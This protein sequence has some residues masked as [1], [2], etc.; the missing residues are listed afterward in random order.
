MGPEDLDRAVQR[1]PPEV[2]PD[3]L[4]GI[5]TSD[6]AGV[7]R[8]A[9][10]RALV[11]TVDLIT[12]V[13]DDPF[14]FG[15]I[16]AANS[17]SDVYAMGGVPLTAM[18]ILAFPVGD[19]SLEVAEQILLGGLAAVHEAGAVLVGGHSVKDRELKYGLSVTGMVHP[20][21]IWRNRGTL[22]GDVAILTKPLGTGIVATAVKGGLAR[23]GWV[24][25][26]VHQASALNRR[27]AEI[28]GGYPVRACT[29]ITGFG[30]GG[31][32]LEVARASG[33]VLEVETSRLPL[34]PGALES[35]RMGLVPAGGHTNRAHFGAW[36]TVSETVSREMLDIVFD[37]QTS[38]GLAVLVAEEAA[39][40]CL[41]ALS[42]AHLAAARIGRV[43]GPEPCGRLV[44]R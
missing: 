34:L 20:R 13:V 1:L 44:L 38:G 29:D 37:P 3:L 8:I 30:L 35:A 22:P 15:R 6:D 42:G 24:E 33:M 12:P 7:F 39:P 19:L 16:A 27:A 28:L 14:A 9:E 36:T 21:R 23:T 5:E 18:N 10:D 32:L 2:H 31:H 4:V 26:M 41:A 11:Q 40:D 43:V 17:L 25:E